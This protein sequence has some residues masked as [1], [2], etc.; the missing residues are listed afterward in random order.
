MN[1]HKRPRPASPL[2]PAAELEQMG[3][4]LVIFPGGIVRALARTAQDYYASL[5]RH[6]SNLPFASRM[7]DFTG[8]NALI[9]TAEM[10]A[11]GR[12]YEGPASRVQ[13][14]PAK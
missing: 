7:F 5:A 11:L 9:G 3:F 14:E 2:L 10:L 4:R 1:T 13:G 6:G 12:A 8:L